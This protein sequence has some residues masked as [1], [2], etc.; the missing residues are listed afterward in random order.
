M[1]CPQLMNYLE[2]IRRCGLVRGSV[3]GGVSLEVD[4]R[5]KSLYLAQC[6]FLCLLS[7]IRI[8]NLSAISSGPCRP[9]AMLPAMIIMDLPSETLSK[10]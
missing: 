6:L 7:T 3:G 1:L 10:P 2:S 8:E 5:L 4:L 9:A